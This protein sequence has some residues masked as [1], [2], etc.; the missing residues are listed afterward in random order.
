[1]SLYNNVGYVSFRN[2]SMAPITVE[3]GAGEAILTLQPNEKR[4]TFFWLYHSHE[5]H[6]STLLSYPNGY[7]YKRHFSLLIGPGHSELF[8]V[9]DAPAPQL[10]L[11]N[12]SSGRPYFRVLEFPSG[13]VTDDSVA[14]ANRS[15]L[16]TEYVADSVVQLEYQEAYTVT[17]ES[18]YSATE[19][20]V[21]R[22]TFTPEP[23][24]SYKMLTC[25]KTGKYG[26][27]C[28]PFKIKNR[29]GGWYDSRVSRAP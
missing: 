15:G 24:F 3:L 17:A 20:Y 26:Q 5:R 8:P 12:R 22:G 28:G 9:S 16:A 19:H 27:N 2:D 6:V 14:K 11:Q 29:G 10:F 13:I 21:A 4:P 23:G 1:M 7:H 25:G 18:T